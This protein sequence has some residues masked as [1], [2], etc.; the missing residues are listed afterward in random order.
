MSK[1]NQ[2][3]GW[4]CAV[5][6]IILCTT[7]GKAQEPRFLQQNDATGL[8]VME[9]ENYTEMVTPV[10]TYWDTTS[11]PP[12]YSG[13]CAVQTFPAGENRH[14]QLSDAQ[15]NAPYLT[16]PVYFVKAEPLF[17]WIRASHTDGYDDSAWFG[18]DDSIEGEAPIQFTTDE[19]QY[20]NEWYWI[21][22]LMTSSNDRA[23]LD[24]PSVGLHVFKL[25]MRE[26]SFKADK[27]LLT[28]DETYTP[29]D[30]GP[31]ETL[32]TSGVKT[33]GKNPDSFGLLANY[34]N[35]FNTETIIQYRID[36]A[37]P[38]TLSIYTMNGILIRHLCSHQNNTPGIYTV[39]WDGRTDKGEM[40]PTGVYICK[41]T[42]PS[43][44]AMIKMMML[45]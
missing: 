29:T 2:F 15:L 24:V 20:Q 31:A 12:G 11:F 36:Y 41:L 18:L 14:K 8:V 19:Q 9:A 43:S 38:V 5:W 17:V 1:K 3:A 40:T 39:T 32:Y 16:Y 44:T 34:P 45:K 21:S 7:L 4:I 10:S 23:I 35:P 13:T 33:K 28:T 25:Y 42:T 22:H 26:P 37:E 27:I 6:T 30:V